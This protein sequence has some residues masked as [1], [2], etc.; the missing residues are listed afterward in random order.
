MLIKIV[1][2][3]HKIL[4]SISLTIF[5]GKARIKKR[6]RLNEY[7]F[8]VATKKENL[9][10]ECYVEWQIS[11]GTDKNLEDLSSF[12]FYFYNWK[13]ISNQKLL[14]IKHFL[15]SIDASQ[16]I[17]KLTITRSEFESKNFLGFNFSVSQVK[18]PLLVYA[19]NNFVIEIV[20]RERQRANGV[21]PMLYLCFPI[22]EL[23]TDEPL[24]NRTTQSNEKADLE[25]NETNIFT[26]LEIF[27]MFGI[28]SE[29]HR[30]DVLSIINVILKE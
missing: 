24:L 17:D 21:Q 11:Y 25:I 30:K 4:V 1:E 3:E 19:S 15:E 26:F 23:K 12:I 27:K 18:Y 14:E 9:S 29:N 22:T 2:E 8:S 28:L 16:L 13:V 10:E 5:Q 20:N 6:D 7:G